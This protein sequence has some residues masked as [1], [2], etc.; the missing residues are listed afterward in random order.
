[1]TLD[2]LFRLT[3]PSLAVALVIA[4]VTASSIRVAAHKAITSKY[5]Y[6]GEVFPILHEKCGRCHHDGGVAPM[7]LL[8][9]NE[10]GRGAFA[11]AESMREMLSIGAMPPWY[12]DPT[13]PRMKNDHRLTARELDVLL[14]WAAG[15]APEGDPARRPT[16][17]VVPTTWALGPPDHEFVMPEAV[18]IPA[19]EMEREVDVTLSTNFAAPV[20]IRGADLRPGLPSMV[21]RAR[22]TTDDGA[23]LSLWE[24]GHAPVSA[25]SGAAFKI[26]AGGRLHVHI[27]YRKSWL[28]EQESTS[29]QSTIG[30]Y[31][32]DPPLSGKPIDAVVID[33]PNQ[34]GSDQPVSFTGY[35]AVP[36]RV[37]AVRP[38]L[39]MPYDS[40]QIEARTPSGRVIAIAQFRGAR[41]EWPRRYWLAEAQELPAGSTIEV[42]AAPG[43]PDSGPLIKPTTEPLT[44]TLDVVQ[45][46]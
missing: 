4:G 29:D 42:T 45:L 6:N 31:L 23:V 34:A 32:A 19:G 8:S 15:G 35:L 3:T 26:P 22:I 2:N 1:M 46:S 17:P 39:D 38:S 9:Y 5:T 28:Q 40:M 43:D 44:V 24:P 21:R 36:A 10:E 14:T 37:I 7:S 11:W 27:W 30:L 12:A 41:P 25:P 13:G 18:T 20:W 33:G 16:A